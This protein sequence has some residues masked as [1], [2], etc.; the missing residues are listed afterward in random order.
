MGNGKL[1][2]KQRTLPGNT[3]QQRLRTGESSYPESLDLMLLQSSD[4]VF[5]VKES[6]TLH[7]LHRLRFWEAEPF[8]RQVAG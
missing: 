8:L 1:Q 7:G 2:Q 3:L 5:N 4:P 6:L